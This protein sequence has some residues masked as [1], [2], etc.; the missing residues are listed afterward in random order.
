MNSGLERICNANN[1]AEAFK[2]ARKETRWKESVQRYEANLLVNLYQTQKSIRNG[3]YKPK[4]LTEFNISERG[5]VRHIKAQ[6]I[7]DRVVQ[8]SLTDNVLLPAIRPKLIYD[9]GASLKDKR[10]DFCRK[11][12]F[13]HLHKAHKLWGEDFWILSIDFTKYFDNLRHQQGA[14][15]LQGSISPAELGFVSNRVKDFEVDVSY[16]TDE[17]YANCMETAYNS[18]A[19]IG[20]PKT[21]QKMMAKSMPIG[22]HIS[23]VFGVLYP[24]E[25]DN[26]F[27]IVKRFKFYGRYMDDTYVMHN[28][29]DELEEAYQ[30]AQRICKRLGLFIN[31]K[32]THIRHIRHGTQFLKTNVRFNK[33]GR[34]IRTPH[35][36]LWQRQRRR[37]RRFRRLL[38]NGRMTMQDIL[39][40]YKGWRGTYYKQGSK[41]KIHRIDVYFTE[42]F[43]KELADEYRRNDPKSRRIAIQNKWLEMRLIK[44]CVSYRGLESYQM[45]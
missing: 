3:T 28:N 24:T 10:L 14:A 45:L 7:S 25:L 41:N 30:E 8:R 22:N 31:T 42:V 18:L 19:D 11:R 36:S 21:G 29:R 9:N 23:Q 5:H 39:N 20:K 40:C 32:K 44:P 1:L 26:Y 15:V 2:Q 6:H 38:D 43:A 4:A 17:Q 12:F 35:K 33:R 34:T 27:K 16:M 13:V 37:I